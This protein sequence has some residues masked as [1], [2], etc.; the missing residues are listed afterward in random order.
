MNDIGLIERCAV[1]SYLTL[2]SFTFLA[3]RLLMTLRIL[4]IMLSE[5]EQYEALYHVLS[6]SWGTQLDRQTSMKMLLIESGFVIRRVGRP[7]E[8]VALPRSLRLL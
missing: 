8:E 5:Q 2:G 1:P 3:Y 7:R 6:C 4:R